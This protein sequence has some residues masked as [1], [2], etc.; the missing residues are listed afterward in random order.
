MVANERRDANTTCMRRRPAATQPWCY[1][2]RL[3][4][5]TAAAATAPADAEPKSP[6]QPRSRLPP[7]SSTP[8]HLFQSLEPQA[9]P[10]GSKPAAH[11]RQPTAHARPPLPRNRPGRRR[12]H[13]HTLPPCHGGASAWR[14]RGARRRRPGGRARTR[15]MRCMRTVDSVL[16]PARRRTC[17]AWREPPGCHGRCGRA[18]ARGRRAA[19]R[20]AHVQAAGARRRARYGAARRSARAVGRALPRAAGLAGRRRS[21]RHDEHCNACRG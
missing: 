8:E 6:R 21:S 20:S 17:P 7:H 5:I 2:C 18:T 12:A 9:D 15:R 3:R 19:R 16:A 11:A 1:C 4:A 10:G 14:G 13:T